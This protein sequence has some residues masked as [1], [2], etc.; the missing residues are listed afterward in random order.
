MERAR[1]RRDDGFPDSLDT[2]LSDRL[3]SFMCP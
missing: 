1:Q 2:M 3:E